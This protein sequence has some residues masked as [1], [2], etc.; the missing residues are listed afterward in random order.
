MAKSCNKPLIEKVAKIA[1]QADVCFLQALI[2]IWQGKT[3]NRV[4]IVPKL[5]KDLAPKERYSIFSSSALRQEK[6]RF[7]LRTETKRLFYAYH[8]LYQ[9][10]AFNVS[11]RNKGIA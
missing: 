11:G 10:S 8:Q 1:I 4:P 2:R 5:R 6:R 7:F 9:A 3:P